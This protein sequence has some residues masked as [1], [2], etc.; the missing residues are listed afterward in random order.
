[1]D[2]MHD[3]ILTYQKSDAFKVNILP[4]TSKQDDA[5][6][7]ICP[8]VTTQCH[9]GRDTRST[10]F[11]HRRAVHNFTLPEETL[12]ALQTTGGSA[13]IQAE[14]STVIRWRIQNIT[15]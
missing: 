10:D 5:Y 1:M 15:S 11:A 12:F 9:Q 3:F 7:V 6:P 13:K 14:S 8:S 2:A 4:R